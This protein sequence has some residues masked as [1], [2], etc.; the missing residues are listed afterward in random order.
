VLAT[1][2]SVDG[3]T[4]R[5]TKRRSAAAD[6][7]TAVVELVG[8]A[9]DTAYSYQVLLDGEAAP[10]DVDLRLRFRTH[11]ARGSRTSFKVLFGG[12]S[13]WTPRNETMWS[14]ILAQRPRAFLALGDN[15]YYNIPDRIEHP[16]HLF[17]ARHSRPEYRRLVSSIPQYAIWDDHDFAGNDSVGGPKIEEPAWKKD[18]VLPVFRQN[19][20]NPYYGGGEQQPGVWHHFT[21]GDVDFFMLDGRYYKTD[22]RGEVPLYTDA[23]AAHASML[24]PVQKAWLKEKLAAST[25]TF[26][27]IASPVPWAF[28]TKSG[29]QR[30][31][32]LGLRLGADD[33]WEGMPEER[34]EIFSFIEANRIEGVFLLSSDR[35]RSDA[36]KIERSRGYDFYEASTGHLT[37]NSSAP[38]MPG[39]LFTSP[40]AP[41]AGILTFDFSQEEPQIV[42]QIMKLD[43]Y[44]VPKAL[45]VG[46]NQLTFGRSDAARK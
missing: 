40:G 27:V 26:K 38:A 42:Y 20:V 46:L 18:V 28:G 41:A 10:N 21:I 6:D 37:K 44:I 15:N 43:G 34:E 24:G 33:T 45:R 35:H 11:P 39:A 25:A 17:Y 4:I 14:T 1:G 19:W 29:R 23:D 9:P 36:W 7:F 3:P 5:S 32:Q 2:A 30:T 22:P 31:A 13:N 12:C 8:L 16:R